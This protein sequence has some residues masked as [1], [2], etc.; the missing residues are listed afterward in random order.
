LKTLDLNGTAK[1]P[2]TWAGQWESQNWFDIAREYTE[3]WHHQM[4]IRL[5][6]NKPG[7]CSKELFHPVID[8]F[9]RGL[10][11]VYHRVHA[12]NGE[13]I[14]I[15]IIGEGGGF[16]FLEKKKEHWCLVKTLKSNPKVKIKMSR[17]IAWQFFTDSIPRDKAAKEMKVFGI[18]ALAEPILTMR[19]VLR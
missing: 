19:T 7:I 12:E 15:E 17:E 5:A 18:N 6:V 10:P 11:H 14:E 8:S 9:M 3:K 4:Q 2:V 1:L 16:W 13:G